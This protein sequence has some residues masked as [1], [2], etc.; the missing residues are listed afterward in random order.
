MTTKPFYIIY[1]YIMGIV[2][3]I[4]LFL[5]YRSILCPKF[6]SFLMAFTAGTWLIGLIGDDYYNVKGKN[7]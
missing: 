1:M 7:Y 4:I 2:F 5:F 6:I 3:F